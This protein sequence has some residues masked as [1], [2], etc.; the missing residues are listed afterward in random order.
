M[1]DILQKLSSSQIVRSKKFKYT[2]AGVIITIV[3]T[4]FGVDPD[5]IWQID[6]LIGFL[7]T[8]QG[9]ADFGKH[10]NPKITDE[11]LEMAL[12][13]GIEKSPVETSHNKKR[14]LKTVLTTVLKK[15]IFKI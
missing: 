15:A 13:E 10:Q 7:V 5:T 14:I 4:A 9:I 2:A 12:D 11:E 6:A 1:K 8:G 3:L